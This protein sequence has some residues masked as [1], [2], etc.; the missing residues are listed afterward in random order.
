[1]ATT[2]NYGWT[3]PNDSD[4]FKLGASAIRT[5]GNSVDTT[6][7]TAL[8]G[9]YPG[10]RFIKSQAVGT[11]VPNVSV[12]GAFSATFDDYKILY[13]GGASS[14]SSPYLYLSL[15]G[16]TTG[17]FT[18]GTFQ[19]LVSATVN[20]FNFPATTVF[21]AGAMGQVRTRFECDLTDPFNAIPTEF[22]S[23]WANYDNTSSTTG[24]AGGTN[25][26]STSA[27]GFTLAPA[28]GTITG[29]TIYVYGYGKS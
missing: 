1:M 16:I 13:V 28:S 26:A 6:L 9:A 7:G 27:T 20:T 23:K 19:S 15:N 3:T 29:G 21:Y 12:T 11:A 10:L 18:S 2:T 4:A 24:T 22:N 14:V 25:V 5:L 17:Y 8:G